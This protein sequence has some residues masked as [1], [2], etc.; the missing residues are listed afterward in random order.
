MS[1][2]ADFAGQIN[3]FYRKTAVDQ[4]VLL[5]WYVEAKEGRSFFD[6]EMLRKCFRDASIDPPDMSVYLPRLA[7]KKPPQLVRE[8]TGYRLASAIRRELD[9]RLG[10]D[11]TTAAVA[12]VLADL[13]SKI[14]DV[15]ERDFLAETLNCY[16]VKAYRAAITMAWNL[17]Y[18]HLLRWIFGDTNRIAKFNAGIVSKYPKKNLVVA[19][20]EDADPLK[21]SEV[22]EIARAGKL[23]DKNTTQILQDKL[24]RRNMAAHPSRVVISQHQADDAITDLVANVVLKLT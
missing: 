20:I 18:D 2:V 3:G 17:A 19:V 14:P 1:G 4:L 24:T 10:G 13:P 12:K 8:K 16:K 11:P 22:I 23:L 21:E 7:K 5:A 15:S 9:A 6:G